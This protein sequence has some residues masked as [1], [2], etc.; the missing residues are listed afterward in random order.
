MGEIHVEVRRTGADEVEWLYEGAF[1]LA[2]VTLGVS[3]LAVPIIF[4]GHRS[5][6]LLVYRRSWTMKVSAQTWSRYFRYPSKAAALADVDR[7]RAL[8]IE[9][10]SPEPGKP[11]QP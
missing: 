4:V 6:W 2:W 11:T 8:A 3:L 1:E 5:M 7:Q 9:W 10:S